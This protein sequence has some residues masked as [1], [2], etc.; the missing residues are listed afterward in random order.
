[1]MPCL[2]ARRLLPLSA[3]CS[4]LWRELYSVLCLLPCG[5]SKSMQVEEMLTI[6]VKP[7]WKKG[8]KIG[9]PYRPCFHIIDEKNQCLH[10]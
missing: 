5:C 7:G 8:T 10:S 1:M 9:V 4:A 2:G 6:N 3:S